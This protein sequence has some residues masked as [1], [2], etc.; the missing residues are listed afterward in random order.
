M[1]P[2]LAKEIIATLP[3]GRTLFRYFRDRYALSLLQLAFPEGESIARIKRSRFSGLLQKNTTKR[4]LAHLG[5]NDLHPDDLEYHWPREITTYR[6]TL[7][8]WPEGDEKWM[9]HYHQTTR[10]GH[11]L[12][13]RLN[14]SV[15]HNDEMA[16]ITGQDVSEYNSWCFHPVEKK[17]EL[18]LAWSRIDLDFETGEALI[19]EIQSDWVRDARTWARWGKKNKLDAGWTKYMESKFRPQLR[20]WD[21]TIMAAT[22]WFLTH[23]IGIRDIFYHTHQTGAV[24]KNIED[25]L[26]PRSLYTDLPRR[27]CFDQTCNGP[28]FIRDQA[29]RRVRQTFAQPETR[30]HYLELGNSR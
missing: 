26:P 21:E 30:W 5:S 3:Q 14:F 4:L 6:L 20:I 10:R 11:N 24:M 28:L 19:E 13:L 22:L 16:K 2:Q 25:T 17:Q 7:D 27:F 12:V 8:H 18:T 9:R 29:E 23:E 15:S 1:T